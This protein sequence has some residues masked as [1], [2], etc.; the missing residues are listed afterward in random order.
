MMVY[1]VLL[2][3]T[4]RWASWRTD[5]AYAPVPQPLTRA[6]HFSLVGHDMNILGSYYQ[7]YGS[8]LKDMLNS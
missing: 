2:T 6:V 3:T 1:G 7:E 5:Q 8:R 4:L